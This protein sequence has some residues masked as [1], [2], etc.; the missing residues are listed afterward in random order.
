MAFIFSDVNYDRENFCGYKNLV[1]RCEEM[2]L[3][4]NREQDGE[5]NYWS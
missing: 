1:S 5:E 4:G 2:V 3:E